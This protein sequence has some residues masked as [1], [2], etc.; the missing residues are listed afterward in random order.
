MNNFVDF[1]LKTEFSIGHAFGNVDK[2]IKVALKN[3]L[4]HLPISDYGSV[5]NWVKQYFEC[6]KKGIIPILGLT[7]FIKDNI[8]K[9]IDNEEVYC[10]L[11]N[12]ITMPLSKTNE[13]QKDLTTITHQAM[14]FAKNIKGYYNLIKIHNIMQLNQDSEVS[15]DTKTLLQYGVGIVCIL[16]IESSR[17][18]EMLFNKEDAKECYEMFVDSF[19]EVVLSLQISENIHRYHLQEVA[20][21]CA[22][23]LATIIPVG[24]CRYPE[25]ED[26]GAFNIM[27]RISR[28]RN[29]K[30]VD[31]DNDANMHLKTVDELKKEFLSNAQENDELFTETVF[32]S[33]I[34]NLNSLVSEFKKIDVDTTPKMPKIENAEKRLAKKA[35]EGLIKRGKANNP[36]YVK[37][38]EYELGNIIKAG[39]ADYFLF[40]EDV[41]SWY[42]DEKKCMMS[43]GRGCF[44]PKMRV[45]MS[46]GLYKYIDNIKVGDKVYT[47]NSNIETVNHVFEYDVEEEI[48]VIEFDDTIIECTKDHKILVNRNNQKE[49]I[50]AKDLMEGD[51]VIDV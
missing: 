9:V 5:G 51:D 23:N 35:A 26:K 47:A 43:S 10:D 15:I 17:L 12:D 19:D 30:R 41:V 44:T 13:V 42:I 3:G 24:N 16:P 36:E 21:F 20:K 2:Y 1:S 45:K 18:G 40:L 29:S 27:T 31:Y 28:L 34:R 50:E 49:W 38:L 14:L 32:Q 22:D 48:C 25:R 4:T 37:R 7:V 39:F 8:V 11:L 6:D 46:D 33:L